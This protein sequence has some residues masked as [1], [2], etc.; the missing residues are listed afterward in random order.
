M[1]LTIC[2]SGGKHGRKFCA[3]NTTLHTLMSIM[4]VANE[5][6]VRWIWT[7]PV[8]SCAVNLRE[9]NASSNSLMSIR[10]DLDVAR[11]RYKGKYV[12][13]L[14]VIKHKNFAQE[15]W[16]RYEFAVGCCRSLSFPWKL[17]LSNTLPEMRGKAGSG[18]RLM[19]AYEYVAVDGDNSSVPKSTGQSAKGTANTV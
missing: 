17:S 19:F 5:G 11:L 4:K 15:I 16:A 8:G 1:V 7:L 10:K 12:W 18:H 14:M 3:R 2:E 6:K 13:T 9:K